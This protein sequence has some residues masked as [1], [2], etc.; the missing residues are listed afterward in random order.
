MQVVV[1]PRGWSRATGSTVSPRPA[2]TPAPPR[3]YA[4]EG[5]SQFLTSFPQPQ[6]IAH[7]ESIMFA[8]TPFFL[9]PLKCNCGKEGRA[10]WGSI[11]AS[12]ETCQKRYKGELS[13][14]L[15]AHKRCRTSLQMALASCESLGSPTAVPAIQ[16]G[17]RECMH[18]R[19]S[20][21]IPVEVSST[22]Q[23]SKL[24][25]SQSQNS[26]CLYHILMHLSIS[27]HK[28]ERTFIPYCSL[29]STQ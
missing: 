26:I 24:Y 5:W 4:E 2:R 7:P 23:S 20:E 27:I 25:L 1:T 17:K 3:I 28:S 13:R 18:T 14:E 6:K 22:E 10:D 11:S 19:V 21:E 16:L 15:Q 12:M 8:T 29:C 9:L